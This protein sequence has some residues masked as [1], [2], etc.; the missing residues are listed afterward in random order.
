VKGESLSKPLGEGVRRTLST[1]ERP[2][3]IIVTSSDSRIVPEHVF[4]TGLG[5]LFVIRTAGNVCDPHTLASIEYAAESLGS[6]LCVVLAAGGC[7]AVRLAARDPSKHES[8][9]VSELAE[10]IGPA[11][12]RSSSLRALRQ[13]GHFRILVARYD[14]R[15]GHVDWLP[16][17]HFADRTHIRPHHRQKLRGLSP[18][19]ALRMLQAGHRRFLSP[20]RPTGDISKERRLRMVRSQEAMAVVITCSDS[21]VAPEHLFDAGLG[22]LYVVRVAGNALNDQAL[23][24]VEFAMANTGASVV[25]VLGHTDCGLV[26]T[27]IQH[28]HDSNLSPSMRHLLHK[29]EPAVEIARQRA[30]DPKDLQSE[31]TKTNALRVLIELRSRSPFLSRLEREGRC[32]LLAALYQVKTGDIT[33]LEDDEAARLPAPNKGPD[34]DVP[35]DLE[36][37]TPLLTTTTT[38]TTT[39]PKTT[40]LPA[41]PAVE[42]RP[43]EQPQPIATLKK[44]GV[45]FE[46]LEPPPPTAETNVMQ[47]RRALFLTLLSAILVA[48]ACM[49]AYSLWRRRTSE[50]E[51]DYEEEEE[52][53]EE[54]EEDYEDY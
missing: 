26:A 33:W 34:A 17:R 44:T 42:P 47:R 52:E 27:A 46:P 36:P 18:H 15:D 16:E 24:S 30:P 11:L 20:T 8:R 54:G 32:S 19:V 43:N 9:V 40:N 28:A 5:E 2:Y 45:R 29:I 10:R 6:E 25:V 4:N 37:T 49:L 3:A 14:S 53:G 12:R 38:T 7:S 51:E 48:A 41:T 21:R 35:P 1:G 31:A 50:D 22:E 23:A 13:T 39:P